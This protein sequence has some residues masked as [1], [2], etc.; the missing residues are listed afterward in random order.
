MRRNIW[1]VLV[2]LGLVALWAVGRAPLERSIVR[3]FLATYTQ[4]FLGRPFTAESVSTEGDVLV[5]RKVSLQGPA[6]YSLDVEQINV[7]YTLSFWN[8]SIDAQIELVKPRL[9]LVRGALVD[10][11]HHSDP[12]EPQWWLPRIALKVS[13]GEIAWINGGK[14]VIAAMV[15]ADLT[16]G[17]QMLAGNATLA[18]PGKGSRGL[19]INLAEQGT[20]T[21]AALRLHSVPADLMFV[22]GRYLSGFNS[23]ADVTQGTLT[24]VI[25]LVSG[26]TGIWRPSGN[27]VL[28]D[29]VTVF[30]GDSPQLRVREARLSF[31]PSAD[32]E[33]QT[34][35]AQGSLQLVANSPAPDGKPLIW[36]LD[37]FK[38]HFALDTSGNVG[39]SCRGQWWHD[40]RVK[41]LRLDGKGNGFALD[42]ASLAFVGTDG[43]EGKV[44]LSTKGRGATLAKVVGLDATELSFLVQVLARRVELLKSWSIANGTLDGT[45]LIGNGQ[46]EL[47]D[48]VARGLELKSEPYGFAMGFETCT[49]R[50]ALEIDS[51]GVRNVLGGELAL[52]GGE[53][54]FAAKEGLLGLSTDISGS[55]AFNSHSITQIE[56]QGGFPLDK[57]RWSIQQRNGW[58]V[59]LATSGRSLA[60]LLPEQ[61]RAPISETLGEQLFTLKAK[62]QGNVCHGELLTSDGKDRF[63]FS[64]HLSPTPDNWLSPGESLGVWPT[65]LRTFFS[66]GQ[67]LNPVAQAKAEMQHPLAIQEGS[68]EGRGLSLPRYLGALLPGQD[69]SGI[70]GTADIRGNFD[71]KRLIVDISLLNG[72]WDHPHFRIDATGSHIPL[73]RPSVDPQSGYVLVRMPFSGTSFYDKTHHLAFTDISGVAEFRG[74]RIV[75]KDLEA[76]SEGMTFGVDVTIKDPLQPGGPSEYRLQSREASGSVVQLKTLMSH[77]DGGAGVLHK[78]PLDGIVA[79]NTDGGLLIARPNADGLGIEASLNG[80]VRDAKIVQG[81]GDVTVR[82]LGM[83]FAYRYPENTLAVSDLQGTVLVGRQG[84]S[85]EEYRLAGDRIMVHQYPKG[86]VEFDLWVGDKV[87]DVLRVTGEAHSTAVEGSHTLT[88][89][90]FD[91]KNTHFGNVHP[92]NLQLGLRDWSQIVLFNADMDFDLSTTLRDIQRLSRTGLTGLSKRIIDEVQDMPSAEGDFSVSLSYDRTIPTFTYK[93]M[94]HEIK[95]YDQTVHHAY[96]AGSVQGDNWLVD[97]LKID[98]LSVAADVQ[99]QGDKWKINFLGVRAT[100]ALT[101]GLEGD[102]DPEEETFTGRVNLF[103]VNMSR[104]KEWHVTRRFAEAYD[105]KGDV[106]A[107]GRLVAVLCPSP[108]WC[109]IQGDFE[110]L[111]RSIEIGGIRFRD[112]QHVATRFDSDRGLSLQKIQTALL[113]SRSSDKPVEIRIDQVSYNIA[114]NELSVDG[115]SFKTPHGP[116][117]RLAEAL[118]AKWGNLAFQVTRDLFDKVVSKDGIGG[119]FSFQLAPGTSSVQLGLDSGV[120]FYNNHPYVLKDFLATYNPYELKVGGQFEYRG[121]PLW[122]TFRN[123][124]PISPYGQLFLSDQQPDRNETVRDRSLAVNW[125]F[126]PKKGFTI[127]KVDGHLFGLDA[128]LVAEDSPFNSSPYHTLTGQVTVDAQEVAPLLSAEFVQGVRDAG[129]Q[130]TYV[131]DG[132]WQVSSL[133]PEWVTFDGKATTDRWQIAGYSLNSF[134]ASMELSSKQLKLRNVR[135]EDPAGVIRMPEVTLAKQQGRRWRLSIPEAVATDLT[136]SA[137]RRSDESGKKRRHDVSF[138]SITLS[139]L[140][141]EM[142]DLSTFAGEGTAR[143]IHASKKKSPKGLLGFTSDL[144]SRIGLDLEMVTPASGIVEYQIRDRKVVLTRLKDTYSQG[145]LAKFALPKDGKPS[146]IGFNGNLDIAVRLKPNQPLLKLADKMTFLIQGTLKKPICSL[147]Q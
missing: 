102:Y 35:Q 100:R 62:L 134:E 136:P 6:P 97:H 39:F 91:L 26:D 89:F 124:C 133:L 127:Q 13:D 76:A 132:K 88:R 139:N 32:R 138:P 128:H 79:L 4:S 11:D 49:G 31:D 64:C 140:S 65:A 58:N 116:M 121:K 101:M 84:R 23:R 123:E 47:S 38:G 83:R 1:L 71:A 2:F 8:A 48:L 82:E 17:A 25:H 33:G 107:Q 115:G 98:D 144:M 135:V 30:G 70:S 78:L 50:A 105:P 108:D 75:V 87:R 113:P 104:L 57:G 112:A 95:L 122:V 131:L 66:H 99:A 120:Y 94:G 67:Q 29:I 77:L 3:S 72:L 80:E 73:A 15:T 12:K 22:L 14:E 55:L 81:S 114:Q 96:L 53:A 126:E 147:E 68:F 46:A 106:R 145:K 130:A 20:Q 41:A 28:Q 56:L 92:S 146:T 111:F 69:T 59:Q 60:L 109:H 16:A 19:Q 51:G 7:S 61:A 54:G 125:E 63:T 36:S 90:A 93:V 117:G 40:G 86:F 110:T 129:L 103:E 119:R 43:I 45:V 18:I 44:D 118:K 143:F 5:L 137:L 10:T 27:L 142:S 9:G 24:G 42:A 52:A 34:I 21:A 37:A 141:G 74:D 85:V